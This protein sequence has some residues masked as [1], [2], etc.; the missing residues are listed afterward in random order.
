M[1]YQDYKQEWEDFFTTPMR[2]SFNSA[3]I[4]MSRVS[5]EEPLDLAEAI[6]SRL[7]TNFAN[8]NSF[9]RFHRAMVVNEWADQ[10]VRKDLIERAIALIEKTRKDDCNE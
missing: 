4:D 6:V 10:F 5:D 7:I 2:F 8:R 1:E 3:T 9:G